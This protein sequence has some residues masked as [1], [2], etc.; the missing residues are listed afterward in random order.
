M[1]QKKNGT[2]IK[3]SPKEGRGEN[4]AWKKNN[5]K[6][7]GINPFTSVILL[8]QKKKKIKMAK[9]WMKSQSNKIQLYD[10][11]RN[12]YLKKDTDGYGYGTAPAL[13]SNIV[14]QPPPQKRHRKSEV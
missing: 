12:I 3:I 2:T 6:I 14:L 11:F 4:M 9:D 10:N 1:R 13:T 7:A 8:L 5:R